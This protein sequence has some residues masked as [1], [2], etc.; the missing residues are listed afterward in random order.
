MTRAWTA[1]AGSDGTEYR[2]PRKEDQGLH[3]H[4]RDTAT[5]AGNA[6]IGG[7]VKPFTGGQIRENAWGLPSTRS[8]ASP[9]DR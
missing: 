4:N 3:G 2:L 6:A 1:N 7:E 5:C 8:W 9:A